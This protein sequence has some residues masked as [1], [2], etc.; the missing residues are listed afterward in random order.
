AYTEE[1]ARRYDFTRETLINNW[2][3]ISRHPKMK[4]TSLEDLQGKRVALTTGTIHSDAFREIMS[5]FQ[6]GFEAVEVAH[7]RDGMRA[8][9]NEEAD[10]AVINRVISLL[11]GADHGLLE[12]GIIFNPVEVRYAALHGKNPA[13]LAAIDKQLAAQKQDPTSVYNRSLDRWLSSAAINRLPEWVP[14]AV[15]FTV[16]L[17]LILIVSNL[18][19]RKQVATRTAELSES[20]L[21]FRQ[22]AE[23]IN[24]I[25][26]IGSPDWQQ[27]F[28]VSPT[29]ETV[30]DVERES[31]YKDPMLWIN[32]IHADDRDQ[33]M[34][35]LKVKI[36]GDLSNPAFPEFR[37]INKSGLRW[38]RARAYP[39]RDSKG[40]IIRIAGIAEDITESR[41]AY[42]TIDYMAHHDPLTRLSNRFTFEENLG[43]LLEIPV[44]NHTSHALMYIDLDQFKIIN[45]TCGHSAGDQMLIDLTRLLL[46]T[47]NHQG[48][49][50]RL[51]GDEFGLILK[52][53]TLEQAKALGQLLLDT[54]KDF[55]FD[56]DEQRF[57]VG[58]SIGLVMIYDNQLS[59]SELLSAAD[60]A[61]Y[62]AKET[63]R[64]RLQIYS[65]DD[66]QLLQRHGE[67]QWVNRLQSAL[68]DNRFLLYKQSIKPLQSSNQHCSCDEF[69]FRMTDEQGNMVMPGTFIPAAERYELMPQLDRWVVSNVIAHLA[70][71]SRQ[72]D[73]RSSGEPV[74]FINLS[75]QI[76]ND[77]HF[78]S[79]IVQLTQQHQLEPTC[80]CLEITE[81]AAISRMDKAVNFIKE[82][83]SHG[84][85][86]ALDDFGSGMSSFS[87]LKFLP[88]DYVKI[89]GVFIKNLLQDP[90]NSAIVEAITQI[91][92]TAKLKVI[93]EWVEDE[94]VLNKLAEMG[95]DFAQGYA[96][97]KPRA[98][99]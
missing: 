34:A 2:G 78:V 26:W 71:L 58:A 46:R 57:S 42:E 23:N 16:L 35:D 95:I 70:Q 12:T 44:K 54:I 96:I 21:R 49:L 33:V 83:R 52:N 19:I 32:A 6:F 37:I 41:L 8:V 99:N 47:V 80:I 3:T 50:A 11:H 27:I 76:F 55:R 87:Y 72:L 36:N 61:C 22:L 31:L 69:L 86:F 1:R 40:E 89:D 88:V 5:R 62:A 66:A 15:I 85:H 75:G 14:T 67:M 63:G 7:Y 74:A 94:A 51:G 84:F 77:D 92:H 25:F 53:T 10:A 39:I 82:L 13:I 98:I 17:V 90:M 38:I 30:Y 79:F 45:D 68:E 97:N 60:M 43:Q 20:E 28:Y 64:N 65:Q 59:R 93:A 91:S 29:F 48:L 9:E 56:W 24:E 73:R 81:T 18:L 4:I